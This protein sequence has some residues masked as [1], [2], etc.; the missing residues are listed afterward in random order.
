[1]LLSMFDGIGAARLALEHLHWIPSREFSSEILPAA[2]QVSGRRFPRST[3]LGDI[4]NI[5]PQF[6]EDMVSRLPPNAILLVTAGTPCQD[7]STLK[8]SE[9]RGL[10][11]PLLAFFGTWWLLWTL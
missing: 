8:G 1:M 6:V 5:G 2:L 3:Q 11:G 4:K 7:N 9:S 10:G